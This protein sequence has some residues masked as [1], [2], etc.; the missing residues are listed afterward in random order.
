MRDAPRKVTQKVVRTKTG[1]RDSKIAT[2]RN[3]TSPNVM[4]VIA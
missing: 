4:H 2:Q 3:E 1:F